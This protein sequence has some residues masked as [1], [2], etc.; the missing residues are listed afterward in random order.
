MIQVID[1]ATSEP[2]VAT[3]TF[4]ENGALVAAT[5]TEST[6]VVGDGGH[7]DPVS[8]LIDVD[9]DAGLPDGAIEIYIREVV[10]SGGVWQQETSDTPFD[11]GIAY[12]GFGTAVACAVW[13]PHLKE[14]PHT[15]TISAPGYVPQSVDLTVPEA[16][17]RDCRNKT[18]MATVKLQRS[19]P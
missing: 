14:G 8:G 11:G 10:D 4:T 5:C 9:C 1:A 13:I 2:I 18:V 16:S 7:V 15:L 12:C 3:A 19:V 17:S 6:I